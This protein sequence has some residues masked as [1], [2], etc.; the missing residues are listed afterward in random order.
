MKNAA[1]LRSGRTTSCTPEQPPRTALRTGIQ[2]EVAF[3]PTKDGKKR[4]VDEFVGTFSQ[5]LRIERIAGSQTCGNAS[6]MPWIRTLARQLRI[7]TDY[8][9]WYVVN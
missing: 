3:F 6:G 5:F 9:E 4:N 2:S 1:P 7:K 8:M